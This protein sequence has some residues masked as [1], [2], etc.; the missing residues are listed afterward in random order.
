[1][2]AQW[3]LQRAT[4]QSSLLAAPISRALSLHQKTAFALARPDVCCHRSAAGA[5]LEDGLTCQKILPHPTH[6]MGRCC[7]CIHRTADLMSVI[8]SGGNL[9]FHWDRADPEKL[10]KRRR[11]IVCPTDR[12][13]R[14]GNG[15]MGREEACLIK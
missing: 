2:K 6:N 14:R 8:I 12:L 13:Y 11:A 7:I 10:D 1:M 5:K 4:N 3:K 9:L 15:I